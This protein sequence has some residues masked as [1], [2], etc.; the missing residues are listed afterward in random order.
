MKS[1]LQLPFSIEDTRLFRFLKREIEHGVLRKISVGRTTFQ[2]STRDMSSHDLA[3]R[4]FMRGITS[5]EVMAE[6]ALRGIDLERVASRLRLSLLQTAALYQ[7]CAL[8]FWDQLSS[9]L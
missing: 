5:P 3:E 7:Q 8:K 1:E 2:V 9:L 6:E 4:L